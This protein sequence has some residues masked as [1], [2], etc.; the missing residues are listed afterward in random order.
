MDTLQRRNTSYQVKITKVEQFSS[1][2]KITAQN[3]ENA[4][5]KQL[6]CDLVAIYESSKPPID[7]EIELGEIFIART[8]NGCEISYER[9]RILDYDNFSSIALVDF[10]DSGHQGRVRYVDLRAL[11]ENSDL[12]NLSITNEFFLGEL[13]MKKQDGPK[14]RHL[15]S[16]ITNK[17]A[18]MIIMGQNAAG[19]Y[20]DLRFAES[21][22]ARNI[23]LK[24]PILNTI[25]GYISLADQM[26]QLNQVTASPTK[27][28]SEPVP[29]IAKKFTEF[30]LPNEFSIP[31][32]CKVNISS[33]EDGPNE[34]YVQLV[35]SLQQYQDFNIRLRSKRQTFKQADALE[36]DGMYVTL[37]ETDNAQRMQILEKLADELYVVRLI[38]DGV[39]RVV[40]SSQICVLPD[41]MKIPPFA[42]KFALS[43]ID[44][45]K[46][47]RPNELNFYFA[48]LTRNKCLKLR[49]DQKAGSKR[50]PNK[51]SLFLGI[52]DVLSLI[53]NYN[54]RML[55]YE[56]QRSLMKECNYKARI[57]SAESPTLFYVNIVDHFD[58]QKDNHLVG[59]VENFVSCKFENPQVE[60]A[61][62]VRIKGK[63]H[64]AK[65]IDR[66]PNG[67]VSCELI[68]QGRV[69]NFS[70]YN[71]K[72]TV[73]KYMFAPTA[74]KC[75]LYGYETSSTSASDAK[76]FKSICACNATFSMT[77]VD[78][79]DG[80]YQ[81]KL[82]AANH[83]NVI[84]QI[85]QPHS[86]SVSISPHSRARIQRQRSNSFRL[87]PPH[88][89]SS[90][91]KLNDV[92]WSDESIGEQNCSTWSS[93]DDAHSPGAATDQ[94]IAL[95]SH[96]ISP[97]DFTI[98]LKHTLP[99]LRVFLAELQTLGEQGY[100][101]TS[102]EKNEMCLARNP[103]TQEW[104]RGMIV[105][106]S[107]DESNSLVTVKNVDDGCTYSFDNFSEFKRY[108]L[109]CFM[110]PHFGIRCALPVKISRTNMSI[111][112][113]ALMNLIG[114]EIHYKIICIN[115]F[116]NI[117][118][119]NYQR[120]NF[121]EELL[122]ADLATRLNF[123]ISGPG[124]IVHIED[125]S[126]FYVQMD[127]EQSTLLAVKQY[128][129][130]Y[131]FK[132]TELEAGKFVMA[133]S[134][135]DGRWY[136]AKILQV[137]ETDVEV[138]FRDFGNVEKVL[139][140]NIGEISFVFAELDD[141][142][143]CCSLISSAYLDP[144]TKAAVDRLREIA[145]DKKFFIKMIMPEKDRSIVQLLVDTAA[146]D[147]TIP[148]DVG[149]ELI[150]L[151]E[152]VEGPQKKALESSIDSLEDTL[153]LY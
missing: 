109:N 107:F 81:V 28:T 35:N 53:R 147:A 5:Y 63:S 16:M 73:D 43:N 37:F 58:F 117:I 148:K 144:K 14:F 54:P 61:C 139:R 41:E 120:K 25:F 74:Y 32:G 115:Q 142:A 72:L 146:D 44:G 47:L 33:Y 123:I 95:I 110:K 84:D 86:T 104:F 125:M 131:E 91:L 57:L 103:F 98:Q 6:S 46:H 56:P 20:V 140:E 39:K 59:E 7:E 50:E 66:L 18:C 135:I 40:N 108:P 96:V 4:N 141:L 55:K 151:C 68:D 100:P 17:V 38:D 88:M 29:E 8:R 71:V 89:M 51:C 21:S 42:W 150:K 101:L 121:V 92:N 77:V 80:V 145:T 45:I 152:K 113:E 87:N 114:K 85:K 13:V 2:L 111:A 118:D 67:T 62:T 27:S 31:S 22:L 79:K 153:N 94:E 122:R 136:R 70:E 149:D 112:A 132:E 19:K 130:S 102:F 83:K 48:H 138:K 65:V 119:I 12:R 1:F 128:E 93:E 99:D 134:G 105:D 126:E 60:N 15:E 97:I 133:K 82:E 137:F 23:I 36:V 124:R 11:P 116:I 76:A 52:L 129:T 127:Q 106:S 24:H 69:E 78:C 49:L 34:F 10:F 9:C 90:P 26:A 3:I 75:S 143:H 64:R 30:P